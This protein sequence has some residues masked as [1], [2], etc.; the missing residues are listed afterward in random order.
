MREHEEEGTWVLQSLLLW[1]SIF[2]QS[3]P[4]L[5]QQ[6]YPLAIR[7]YHMVNLRSHSLPGQLWCP[8]TRL[9][10]R[11]QVQH[12]PQQAPL[13]GQKDVEGSHFKQ[14]VERSNQHAR[15]R[16]P[17][18]CWL[19]LFHFREFNLRP[20][21]GGITQDVIPQHILCAHS[22]SKRCYGKYKRNQRHGFCL[23][24]ASTLAGDTKQY[25]C[26]REKMPL[27]YLQSNMQ[28]SAN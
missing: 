10:H 2:C 8:Q 5:C 1:G 9:E 22:H 17:V 6:Y 28:T 13:W 4:Y 18:L 24:K 7:P 23:Q 11:Q 25:I 14:Q 3:Q 27:K 12:Q 19:G 16:I 21:Q 20:S 26:E 15:W